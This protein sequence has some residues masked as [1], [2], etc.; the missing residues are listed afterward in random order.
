MNA[1]PS[2]ATGPLPILKIPLRFYGLSSNPHPSRKPEDVDKLDRYVDRLADALKAEIGKFKEK[3]TTNVSEE[4]YRAVRTMPAALFRLPDECE[5]PTALFTI[6]DEHIYYVYSA[7][8]AQ[9]KP[10][11]NLALML[12]GYP[13]YIYYILMSETSSSTM[14][15]Q[16]QENSLK[17]LLGNPFWAIKW[18][19]GHFSDD[20]YKALL[21]SLYQLKEQDAYSAHCYHWLKTRNASYEVKR[22]EINKIL[23]TL[24]SQPYIALITALEYHDIEVDQLLVE[25]EKSPMWSYNWL[26]LVG[27]KRG[28]VN[29]LLGNMTSWVPWGVQYIKDREPTERLRGAGQRA[30]HLAE[31][32]EMVEQIRLKPGNAWWDEWLEPF[33]EEW[34]QKHT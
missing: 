17:V 23:S 1:P 10:D 27:D 14:L 11:P 8:T 24:G 28:N 6:L 32:N 5:V 16:S 30:R 15:S 26:R 7:F 34:E 22:E 18:L 33:L 25:V 20:G 31:A 19:E 4:L 2:P 29:R 12:A 13:E 21:N 3:D 9:P